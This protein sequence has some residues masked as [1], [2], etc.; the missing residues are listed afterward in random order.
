VL[1][2]D[3]DP[4]VRRSLAILLSVCGFHVETFATPTE[5]LESTIPSSNACMVV[6]IGLPEISGLEMCERL[7]RS[8]R[9]LPTVLISG[10]ADLIALALAKQS[11]AVAV[12][13]KPFDEA[14]LLD[15]IYR[16]LAQSEIDSSRSVLET[17]LVELVNDSTGLAAVLQVSPR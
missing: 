5:L 2:V 17:N 15:A 7:K 6:D 16:A 14:P 3:D 1:I 12:L 4:S 13:L 9:A 11:D 8:G 10:G